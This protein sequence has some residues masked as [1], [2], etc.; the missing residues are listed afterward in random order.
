MLNQ[1]L[2]NFDLEQIFTRRDYAAFR[3]VV[4]ARAEYEFHY[5]RQG[6]YL[7]HPNTGVYFKIDGRKC[8]N[9]LWKD[10]YLYCVDYWRGN[11]GAG[12]PFNP[13]SDG[14]ISYD[15]VIN[16]LNKWLGISPPDKKQLSFFDMEMG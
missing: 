8:G 4:E 1:T 13:V 15:E 10:D 2:K 7:P 5:A 14:I 3:H 6:T 9:G 16:L 11:G 12:I